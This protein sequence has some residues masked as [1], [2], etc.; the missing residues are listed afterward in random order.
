MATEYLVQKFRV[1]G[2][3]QTT[4][5]EWHFFNSN[6]DDQ[7]GENRAA[8]EWDTYQEALGQMMRLVPR[9]PGIMLMIQQKV[10]YI[11]E[12]WASARG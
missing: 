12:N 10:Q 9:H 6:D 1:I 2:M 4:M 7:H 8:R 5:N 11:T 3:S